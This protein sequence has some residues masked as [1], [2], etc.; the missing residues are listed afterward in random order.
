MSSK[1]LKELYDCIE[2]TVI[3]ESRDS[4]ITRQ[5]IQSL[6]NHV[7][8][9]S[10]QAY[11]RILVTAIFHGSG[12]KAKQLE[13]VLTDEFFSVQPF[14][15]FNAVLK[16]S[17][18]DREELARPEK[19]GYSQSLHRVFDSTEVFKRK[20]GSGTFHDYLANFDSPEKRYKELK[21]EFKGLGKVSTYHFLKMCGYPTI[22]PDTVIA[23]VFFRLGLLKD[24]E[25]IEAIRKIG[26]DFVK[27]TN[28]SYER[29]DSV[30]VKFGAEG[31][32]DYLGPTTGVC[33]E[34]RPRCEACRAEPFCNYNGI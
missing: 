9:N 29:I 5:K 3:N 6:D 24:K 23:R 12:I 13:K 1:K 33:E 16:L 17:A 4:K 30:L 20:I 26:D 27:A 15:D 2:K 19:I 11:Y 28:H 10:D 31:S 7:Q 18:Q 8:P 25:D 14:S 21:R 34:Q 22:K 32:S